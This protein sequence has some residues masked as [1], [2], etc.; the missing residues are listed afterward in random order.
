MNA[1]ARSLARVTYTRGVNLEARDAQLDLR[2]TLVES[3][4]QTDATRR[5]AEQSYGL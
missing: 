3:A 4:L 5:D 1:L 2:G